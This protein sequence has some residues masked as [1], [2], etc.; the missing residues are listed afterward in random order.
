MVGLLQATELAAQA[1]ATE[2]AEAEEIV[3]EGGISRAA[4]AETGMLSEEAPKAIADQ[5]RAPTAVAVHP[6]WDLEAEA[7]AVAEAEVVVV[8][9]VGDAGRRPRSGIFN[10]RSTE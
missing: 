8:G 7:G 9:A 4:V 5:A 3:S 10:P 2:L 1:M 6:A